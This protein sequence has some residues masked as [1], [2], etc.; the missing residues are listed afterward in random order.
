MSQEHGC[1]TMAA[2]ALRSPS[3]GSRILAEGGVT[4]VVEAMRRH[5][6]AQGLQRQVAIHLQLAQ[7]PGLSFFLLANLSN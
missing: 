7:R 3:N 5:S 6:S 2:M 1:A 4:A